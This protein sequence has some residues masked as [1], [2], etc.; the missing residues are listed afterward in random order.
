MSMLLSI[1]LIMV[2]I[3][4]RTQTIIVFLGGR[5]GGSLRYYET[6]ALALGKDGSLWS[7]GGWLGYS[8][9]VGTMAFGSNTFG[10]ALT[11]CDSE[12][13]SP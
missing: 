11:P 1:L 3:G 5:L 13:A 10:T 7:S 2:G 9:L 4:M 12:A 8:T 6:S